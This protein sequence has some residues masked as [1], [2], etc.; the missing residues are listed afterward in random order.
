[1]AVIGRSLESLLGEE[2]FVR[3]EKAYDSPFI[4]NSLEKV[5]GEE[6]YRKMRNYTFKD[7]YIT[8]FWGGAYSD[9]RDDLK[10]WANKKRRL[11]I[12][13]KA[14]KAIYKF[15]E[16]EARKS[17]YEFSVNAL[18]LN[19]FSYPAGLGIEKGI[20]RVSW[21]QHFR[22]RS[23]GL[24]TNTAGGDLYGMWNDH[25]F[26]KWGVSEKSEL[27]KK[28]IEKLGVEEGTKAYK[29]WEW[30]NQKDNFLKRWS[31]DDYSFALGQF[32]IYFAN[33]TFAGIDTGKKLL[34]GSATTL[35][36]GL[37]GMF[38]GPFR[39]RVRRWFDLPN[40][41]NPPNH[42]ICHEKFKYDKAAKQL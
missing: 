16:T 21:K 15:F 6:R 18:T 28:L 1:M 40:V 30:Y 12:T 39:R 34:I 29:A 17:L 35:G 22:T 7:L 32:A 42:D 11:K 20:F 38:Y 33:M 8:C 2:R 36:A 31:A 24:L 41:T 25:V 27:G 4:A 19:V 14:A 37:L 9:L 26:E 13:D 5:M 23:F 3:W 10:N